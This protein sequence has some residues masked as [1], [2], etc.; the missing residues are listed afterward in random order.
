VL[1]GMKPGTKE[2]LGCFYWLRY[3]D[4]NSDDVKVIGDCLAY[5]LPYGVYAPAELY[6]MASLQRNRKDLE[7]FAQGDADE[8]G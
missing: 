6:D 5:S 2:E 4:M 1:E 3:L 8:E 7:Y